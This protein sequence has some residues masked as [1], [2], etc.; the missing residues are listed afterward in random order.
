MRNGIPTP[1]VFEI[2][3]TFSGQPSLQPRQQYGRGVVYVESSVPDDTYMITFLSRC[4]ETGSMYSIVQEKVNGAIATYNNIGLETKLVDK[5]VTSTVDGYTIFYNYN[6]AVFPVTVIMTNGIPPDEVVL[7]SGSVSYNNSV[8]SF[9]GR[10][11]SGITAVTKMDRLQAIRFQSSFPIDEPGPALLCISYRLNEAVISREFIREGLDPY[12]ALRNSLRPPMI[13][14]TRPTPP[15]PLI[16][17]SN[18]VFQIGTPNIRILEQLHRFSLSCRVSD[19][20]NPDQLTY[21]WRKDGNVLINDNV[22]YLISGDTLT[23]QTTDRPD[24]AGNY[25]CTVINGAGSDT[26]FTVVMI[27]EEVKA[28]TPPPPQPMW[29]TFPFSDVSWFSNNKLLRSLIVII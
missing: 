2:N 5:T 7:T 18:D 11:I 23:I 6:G 16:T 13:D 29:V 17:E 27:E 9:N 1:D 24:D 26:T 3:M 8:L 14:E 12:N 10:N 20:G 22:N 19:S 25:T 21:V 28:T 15:P 4:L